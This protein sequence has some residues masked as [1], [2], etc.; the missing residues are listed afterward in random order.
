MVM[1]GTKKL[2]FSSPTINKIT[3]RLFFS[4]PMVYD[5][6][7]DLF[8]VIDVHDAIPYVN[9]PL[10]A[11]FYALMDSYSEWFPAILTTNNLTN[12]ILTP[13]KFDVKYNL[14]SLIIFFLILY[15][16]I[17][18][19]KIVSALTKQNILFQHTNWTFNQKGTVEV[20][21][22]QNLINHFSHIFSVSIFHSFC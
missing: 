7:Q 17:N 14:T 3:I 15:V 16:F 6:L 12:S 9:D 5:E 22:H 4:H 2:I 20:D 21:F 13:Y 10:Y 18:F 19:F 1:K 11:E 8:D